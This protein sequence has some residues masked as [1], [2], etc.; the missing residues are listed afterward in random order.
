MDADAHPQ[1][2]LTLQAQAVVQ[3]GH[4]IEHAQGAAQR[5]GRVVLVGIGETEVH[6]QPVAQVLGNRAVEPLHHF[7]ASLLVAQDQGL[8]I[9]CVERVGQ[10]GGADQIAKQDGELSTLVRCFG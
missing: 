8:Q 2:L 3:A 9:F 7:G 10:A 5:P 4:G 6:Q 1:P